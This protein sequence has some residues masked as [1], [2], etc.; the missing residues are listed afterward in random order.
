MGE[1]NGYQ[2]A[3]VLNGPELS[4]D[5][6]FF[7]LWYIFHKSWSIEREVCC[8]PEPSV[9]TRALAPATSLKFTTL[10]LFQAAL[11]T[12]GIGNDVVTNNRRFAELLRSTS[13]HVQGCTNS[14][15]VF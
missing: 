3:L 8:K 9:C 7:H 2:G 11:V 15:L 5:P 6:F 1:N 10:S 13:P 12:E 14:Y 4:K